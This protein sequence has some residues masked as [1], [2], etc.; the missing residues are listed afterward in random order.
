MKRISV[1]FILLAGCFW[2][3]MGLFVRSLS[4]YGFSTIQ[5][6]AMRLTVA[7][8]I[9]VILLLVIR[10]ALLRVRRQDLGLL[11]T[12]GLMSIGAM[13]V[14]YFT[15][16]QL[17]SLSVAAI[18][19]YM[20]PV[21]VMIMSAIWLKEKIT[22]KKLVA[23]LLAVA[24]CVCVAGVGQG[25]SVSITAVVTGLLSAVTYGSYSILG[26]AALKK[27]NPFTVTAIAFSAAATA[28]LIGC[29]PWEM[30]PIIQS[31]PQPLKLL[32]LIAGTGMITA[33]IPFVLYTVGLQ[34]V[35]PSKAAVLACSEPVAATLFGLFV[36]REQPDGVAYMGMVFILVAII[37]L[38]VP[39][40]SKKSTDVSGTSVL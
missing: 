34:W 40:F 12:L 13:S 3:A 15:T 9:L 39:P 25:S 6:A 16:I 18:L 19:L 28:L 21:M 14:L 17:S 24:G 4:A 26:T 23:L 1:L 22:S 30:I 20:S 33:V 10:P 8:V 38:N 35:E 37:M 32:G 5:I 11:C 27:Y 31:S 7:A 2:G 36:Y 29:K